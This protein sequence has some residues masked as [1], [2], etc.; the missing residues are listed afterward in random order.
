MGFHPQPNDWSCGPFALKHAL[1]ALGQNVDEQRLARAAGTHWWSGTDEIKLARAARS[2]ECDLPLIRRRNP[3]RAKRRLSGYLRRGVPVLLSVDDWEH[4]IAVVRRQRDSFVV[5]DSNL[6]P[7][8][9]VLS[10]AQLHRRWRYEDSDF[11]EDDPPSLYDMFPVKPR[12]SVAL[13]AD[14]SV[15]RVR[16]LRRP[17]NQGL[18]AYWD[19][20]LGDLLEI[21]RPPSARFNNPLSMAEFLRRNQSLLLSRVLYWHGAVERAEVTRLLRNFRFVAETYGLVIP[22]DSARRAVADISILVA[23]WV[24]ASRGVGDMYGTDAE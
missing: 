5:I 21:C 9:E 18:A 16:F 11:D 7:V 23:M 4:W 13:K 19:V 20:Y 8:L 15:A 10:W 22:A 3:D 1:I 24:V 12:F 14:F 2:S 6:D 17:E